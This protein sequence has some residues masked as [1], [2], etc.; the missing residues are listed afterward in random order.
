MTLQR[1]CVQAYFAGSVRVQ[2]LAI[3]FFIQNEVNNLSNV[4]QRLVQCSSLGVAALENRTFNNIES[5]FVFFHED[6][7]LCLPVFQ[8][9]LGYWHRC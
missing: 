2:N 5:V 4:L 8:G 3:F 1:Y 7:K 9:S 6:R